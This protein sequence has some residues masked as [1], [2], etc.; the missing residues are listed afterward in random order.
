MAII[1]MVLEMSSRPSSNKGVGMT[2]GFWSST[3][4]RNFRKPIWEQFVES[5]QYHPERQRQQ[6]WTR[7]TIIPIPHNL[8]DCRWQ[9]GLWAPDSV[10][11]FAGVAKTC[12]RS[13][14]KFCRGGKNVPEIW[15]EVLQ[16]WQKRAWDFGQAVPQGVKPC[17]EIGL[18]FCTGCKTFPQ[19][20][21]DFCTVGET[22]PG[23]WFILYPGGN[24]L[25]EISDRPYPAPPL[26]SG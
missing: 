21:A 1:G 25:P 4:V 7:D 8:T 5:R 12:L 18:D 22:F 26:L 15:F 19:I 11:P 2:K 20:L 17:P 16:R 23:I 14:L 9:L 13:G 6:L 3:A 24:F 10:E